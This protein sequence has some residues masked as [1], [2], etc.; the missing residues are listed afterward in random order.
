[1]TA[2][3][4]ARL[5]KALVE[6][7]QELASTIDLDE[8]LE[9]LLQ[10]SREVFRFENA[11][12][13][14]LDED[15]EQLVAAAS[16]G[17]DEDAVRR[18]LRLGQG[19]MG[20]AA[21]S[22][23]P[24]LVEDVRTLPDYVAGIPGARSEL[25]VPLLCRNKLIGVINVESARPGAF[26]ADDIEP[27]MTLGRQAAIAIDN[28]RL[29]G[30][31][32]AL[33]AEHQH[34]H[35]FNERILGS[36]SLGVYTVDHDLRITS[37]NRR[38]AEWSGVPADTA[39]GAILP[40]LFPNLVAD[41]VIDRIRAVLQSGVPAKLRV[42]HRSLEGTIHFQ[43]R[44]LAPLYDNGQVTGVVV[45]VEDITEFKRLLDQT[46][47]TEK[48]AEVGRLAAGIAHEINNPLAIIA[49]AMELMRR[50]GELLPFQLEMAEKVELEVERLK[51]LTGGL[52]TFASGREGHLRLVA[53]N[54]LVDEVLRL[55]R[56]ELQ[57]QAVRLETCFAELPLISADPAKL[58]QVVINLV[59]NAAQAMQGD[60]TVTLSTRRRGKRAVELLVSDTGPGV[61]TE[62]RESI[63]NPF[64]TTKPEGEGTGLGL[65]ICR[66]IVSEHG[67]EIVVE[68]PAGGGALFTVRLPVA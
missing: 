65:Y 66:N 54:D 17:Y 24:V 58:K 36:I 60:G 50:E 20:R 23:A 55:V 37:W 64:F 3:K 12:I 4:S 31:L 57:R 51:T 47:Q 61:P 6:I 14:L 30:R 35:Q 9:R 56:F 26:S 32:L 53:L 29:Y 39:V 40:V 52:L 22:L 68:T 18:T 10:V 25:A 44:R 5:L 21:L 8:L 67:G 45:I 63:F 7:G 38:M 1:M 42:T 59:M 28:A 16:Y 33:S 13:R 15:G 2:T 27:L 11:M 19:V 62:L 41:G 48:L 49:Y 46:I 43:K 34:L